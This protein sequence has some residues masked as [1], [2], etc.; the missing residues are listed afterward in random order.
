MHYRIQNYSVAVNSL[1]EPIQDNDLQ[2][3]INMPQP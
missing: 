1:I 2:N 3:Y